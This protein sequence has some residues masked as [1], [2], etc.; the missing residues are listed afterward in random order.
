M[1]VACDHIS[2]CPHSRRF[3]TGMSRLLGAAAWGVPQWYAQSVI[4]SAS[5]KKRK[6]E[7]KKR[8][9]R[10]NASPFH[11]HR[12]RSVVRTLCILRM[13]PHVHFPDF[14]SQPLYSLIAVP[15]ASACLRLSPFVPSD[16]DVFLRELVS[17]A[18]DAC[19]KR[20]F[21]A[22]T[23]GKAADQLT[24]RSVYASNWFSDQNSKRL[25]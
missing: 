3:Y 6:K 7:R 23:D 17:N 11:P 5:E 24:V 13:H 14:I 4:R 1:P 10:K 8:V 2:W 20:R 19:D 12:S 21:L 16:K 9:T 22:L 15:A 25:K 18:A